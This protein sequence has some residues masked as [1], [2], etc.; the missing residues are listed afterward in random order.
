MRLG[1]VRNNV[2]YCGLRFLALVW[3][4]IGSSL[5]QRETWK[6]SLLAA[7]IR[8]LG[9]FGGIWIFL[10]EIPQNMTVFLCESQLSLKV[11]FSLLFVSE[12]DQ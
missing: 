12:K 1:R 2:S 4:G 5:S 10:S 8:G 9:L 11:I 3:S 7:G 6:H